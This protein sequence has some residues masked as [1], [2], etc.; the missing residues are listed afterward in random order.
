MDRHK[1]TFLH[2][3]LYLQKVMLSHP[4]DSCLYKLL[5]MNFHNNQRGNQLI[6]Y[7]SLWSLKK[8]YLGILLHIY[9]LHLSMFDWQNNIVDK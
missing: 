8:Y 7:K 9:I 1:R 4:L 5:L 6:L 2:L 3:D